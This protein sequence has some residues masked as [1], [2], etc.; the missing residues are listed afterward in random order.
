MIYVSGKRRKIK[1]IATLGSRFRECARV[2]SSAFMTL[3]SSK[4]HH[5][6]KRA[7]NTALKN[8]VFPGDRDEKDFF[9]KTVELRGDKKINITYLHCPVFTFEQSPTVLTSDRD[10]SKQ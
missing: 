1:E 2:Y 7:K 9:Q 4:T 5:L 3:L 10:I 6:E 8:R